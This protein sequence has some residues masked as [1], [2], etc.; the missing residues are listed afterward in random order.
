MPFA[1]R[2][3]HGDEHA[4]KEYS[5]GGAEGQ[6]KQHPDQKGAPTAA[7]GQ[8]LGVSMKPELWQIQS[9]T[10]EHEG[11]H[12]QQKRTEK[13]FS[14]FTHCVLYAKHAGASLQ[15]VNQQAAQQGV[16]YDA[17]QR[18]EQTVAENPVSVL[19]VLADKADGGNVGGQRQGDKAVSS[20]SRK[21][22]TTGMEL[23]SS[24]VCSSS[25]GF[26]FSRS[27]T[28]CTS[29]FLNPSGSFRA[30]LKA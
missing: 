18:V 2:C 22:V 24:R 30:C 16:A 28:V 9:V 17:S 14:Q 21:A 20:P 13:P 1:A 7:A 3:R 26:Y 29:P 8:S 23:L 19:N 27:F 4:E 6:G 25:I 15:G 12:K 5:A 10:Y 11:S